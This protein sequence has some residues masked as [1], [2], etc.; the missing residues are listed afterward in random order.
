MGH[1]AMGRGSRG[2]SKN[3]VSEGVSGLRFLVVEKYKIHFICSV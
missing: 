1:G 3:R 2:S